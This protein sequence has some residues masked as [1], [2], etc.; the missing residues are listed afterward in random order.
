MTQYRDYRD[1]S[2]EWD[3]SYDGRLASIQISS[4]LDLDNR[5]A[6]LLV[7][8]NVG[9]DT[10]VSELGNVF[11]AQDN[12]VNNIWLR[13]VGGSPG[14]ERLEWPRLHIHTWNID[15]IS[16][17]SRWSGQDYGFWFRRRTSNL[18]IYIE[19]R[20]F[21]TWYNLDGGGDRPH[22]TGLAWSGPP[23]PEMAIN[24]GRPAKLAINVSPDGPD[25]KNNVH[26][27]FRFIDV[28]GK[29]WRVWRV[30]RPR[31]YWLQDLELSPFRHG[32]DPPG[33]GT[34]R[35]PKFGLHTWDARQAS[36]WSEWNGKR[37][38][39]LLHNGSLAHWT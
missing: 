15:F 20:R 39:L 3:G 34:I 24:D 30:V 36:G 38:G 18:P 35:G 9:R 13:P 23:L 5:H 33:Q 14:R 7:T 21:T 12:E 19:Q 26:L 32:S 8:Y 31:E 10:W 16:G 37:Y 27:G 28:S 29:W 22:E 17:I 2:G 25:P 11:D 6:H 1:W 4:T